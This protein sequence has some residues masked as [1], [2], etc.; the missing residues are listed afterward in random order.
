[1]VDLLL[2]EWFMQGRIGAGIVTS[3]V[4]LEPS[5]YLLVFMPDYPS[6]PSRSP[7][8]KGS[9]NMRKLLLLV[10]S[11][12]TIAPPGLTDAKACG[13]KLLRIGKNFRY[14]Q[15]LAKKHPA[16][17]LIY[18]PPNSIT[19]PGAAAAQIQDYFQKVGHK[20]LAVG[21]IDKINEALRSG[22]YDLILTDFADAATLLRQVEGLP[23][24]TVV[25][26]VLYRRSKAEK[27]A[28]ARQYPVMV[29]DPRDDIDFLMAIDDVMK[30]RATGHKSY[31]AGTGR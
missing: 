28:A 12:S 3:S 29:K 25:L 8:P 18:T 11:L 4:Q 10:L 14:N 22:Q 27:A 5:C 17:M 31:L 1:L 24:R 26:P 7:A 2:T 16:R 15:R 9:I 19:L 13:D 23:S 20:P 21:N 6:S 30:Y